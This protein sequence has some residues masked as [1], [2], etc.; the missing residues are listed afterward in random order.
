MKRQVSKPPKMVY[1]E[2]ELVNLL[3]A[4]DKSAFRYLYDNYSGALFRIVLDKVPDRAIAKDILQ[5]VFVNIW[6]KMYTY[7]S[8]KGR[9]F[10]WMLNIARNLSKDM[11]RSKAYQNRKRNQDIPDKEYLN[12]RALLIHMNTDGIGL[13][14]IVGKLKPDYQVLIN[15]AYF[16]GY[17]F[18]Q[19]TQ[20]EKLPLGTVK[21]RMRLALG[22]LR[23]YLN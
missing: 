9:L 11:V 23:N 19:I 8:A 16:K 1:C 17:T 18:K 7:D 20:I 14:N 15:L 4:G 3:K 10:T 6:C 5:E 13:N 2:Y 12:N 22:E 21:T